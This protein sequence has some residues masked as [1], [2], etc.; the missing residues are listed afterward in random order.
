MPTE[1]HSVPDFLRY[2]IMEFYKVQIVN[3][4]CGELVF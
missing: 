2:L 3:S 1:I 4:H